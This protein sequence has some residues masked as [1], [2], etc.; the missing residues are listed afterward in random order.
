MAEP[1]G[2]P[3]RPR[4]VVVALD[5]SAAS[6]LALEAAAEMAALVGAELHGV[7]VEDVN[8]IRLA[9]LPGSVEM[10]AASLSRRDLD[11]VRMRRALEG[12]ARDLRRELEGIA[13]RASVGWTFEVARGAVLEELLRVA[14]GAGL[15]ALG[16]SGAGFQ[17]ARPG[18]TAR[19]L[20]RAGRQAV[21]LQH[22]SAA[23]GQ[24]VLV[25]GSE[26]SVKR[27]VVAASQLARAVRDG[28]VL[29]IVAPTRERAAE[30][31]NVAVTELAAAKLTP[32]RVTHMVGASADDLVTTARR[33]CPWALVVAAD[34]PHLVPLLEGVACSMLVTA[35]AD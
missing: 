20:A 2:T 34:D 21:W 35:A 25:C 14:E 3:S 12:Q 13:G 5:M 1:E 19:G 4:R 28:V 31:E 32:T 33:L 17:R 29:L 24:L 16:R 11:A 9:E 15:V 30:I 7:L 27:V 18:S 6:R 26:P 10:G 22:P 8:L 23:D